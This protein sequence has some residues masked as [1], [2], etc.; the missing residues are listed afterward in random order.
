MFETSIDADGIAVIKWNIPDR[1]VNVMNETTMAGFRD[2]VEKAIADDAVKGVVIA[3]SKEDFIAGADIDGFLE[4]LSVEAL[5]P[6]FLMFDKVGRLME[7]CGKPFVA[8]IN[9]H[10]L[11]GGFE[12]ALCCHYRI[13]ADN[14]K[15][16]IGL[17]EIGLG[18]LPGGGGTQRIPRMLGLQAGLKMLLDGRKHTVAEAAKMGLV[19]EVVP[20][21]DLLD[22]AKRWALDNPD[23]TQPWDRKGFRIPGGDVQSPTGMQLFP[24]ANAMGRERSF[25]NYPAVQAILSCVYEG[26]QRHIDIGLRVESKYLVNMIRHPVT[27]AMVRTGFFEMAKARKLK[28]R[29][30]GIPKVK[31]GKLGILGAGM[32]GAGIASVSAGRGIDCVLMDVDRAA[33]EAG[34]ARAAA[35][36]EKRVKQGRMG[37]AQM[38][39][40]LDRIA[41]TDDYAA[42]EGSD[43][44][45]EAVFE[46]RAIKA[47]VTKAAEA[48]LAG[49]A[50]FAS[51]TSTL[52][53][54]GLA[55]T[56]ARPANFIGI[57]FFSPVEKMPLVEIIRGAET[58]DAAVALALD[59]VQAIGKTPIVVNDG[60][61]FFTSRVFATY[62]MEGVALLKEGVAPA[63]IENAGKIAGFPVGPLEVVDNTSLGLSLAIRH[64]WKKDLGEAYVG[65]PAD[66]VFELFV[67]TLD[68]PG[69][70]SG[71]GIYAWP[72]DGRAGE[73]KCLWPEL[74][75][76]FTRAAA[77]PDVEEVKRRLLHIQSVEA[78]RC[79]AENVVTGRADA[80]V[81][82]ILGWGFPMYTGGVLSWVGQV[83]AAAFEAQCNALA[84]KH[85]PRFAPP[86]DVAALAA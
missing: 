51:N 30:E 5:L 34:K 36:L 12:T 14:P 8:A 69:R 77:Q 86:A 42:L 49:D 38:A 84:E 81:G 50:V 83:G 73:T 65:H 35:P 70:K 52:P 16:R 2:E 85:G 17:P 31:I 66:D 3:S 37:E 53:I 6:Q 9:G 33:A 43:L 18:V 75:R 54:T 46:D 58:G 1:P 67:E 19:D 57:H 68:R 28:G 60:R 82:S 10:A 48:R 40:L 62:V 74:G 23:A 64:Q 25:G 32:M 26:C 47:D 79:R 71:R 61:G 80:D 15:A 21:E 24:A 76:H 27:K 7:T 29:P 72:A 20:P 78:L 55:T 45:I 4:D 41:P 56:S 44:V 13:A 63:L 39:A 11:G 22:A 59:Y